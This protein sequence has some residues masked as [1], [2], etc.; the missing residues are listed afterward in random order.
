MSEAKEFES[1]FKAKEESDNRKSK[2]ILE[3][4]GQL[5]TIFLVLFILITLAT[6]KN[7]KF[8]KE[9]FELSPWLISFNIALLLVLAITEMGNKMS[10]QEDRKIKFFTLLREKSLEKELK[11]LKEK[12]LKNA[13]KEFD[14]Q[15]SIYQL[16]SAIE[17][18]FILNIALSIVLSIIYFLFYFLFIGMEL[19]NKIITIPYIGQ[20]YFINLLLVIIFFSALWF[21]IKSI[22][23]VA[24]VFA[25]S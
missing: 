18:K 9:M 8:G 16:L 6:Y 24:Y 22:L 23:H 14:N 2:K 3:R 15:S 21:F 17:N 20:G 13:K 12:K 4:R 1:P 7:L 25:D 10:E 5:L 11:F 19:I